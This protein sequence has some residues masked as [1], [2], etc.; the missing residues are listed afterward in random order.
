MKRDAVHD[1]PVGGGAVGE[2][3][4]SG[5]TYDFVVVGSGAGGGPLAAELARGGHSVVVLEA[6]DHHVC[7]V[8]GSDGILCPRGSTLGGSTAVSAMVMIYPHSGDR[9]RLAALTRDPGWTPEAMREHF[10]R[11]ERWCGEESAPLPGDPYAV[12]DGRFRVRNFGLLF[13]EVM[14]GRPPMCA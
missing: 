8:S 9:A 13:T 4:D 1:S 12:L 11:M 2:G 6:G 3:A 10:Q 5:D 7:P 14:G